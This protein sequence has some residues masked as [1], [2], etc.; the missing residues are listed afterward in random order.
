MDKTTKDGL[1]RIWVD[2]HGA[3]LICTDQEPDEKLLLG[4]N[5]EG[6]HELVMMLEDA[7]SAMGQ[8]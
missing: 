3:W 1:L 2:E 8:R 4:K 7:I 5:E 6:L